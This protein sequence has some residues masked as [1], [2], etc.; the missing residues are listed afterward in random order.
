VLWLVSGY[1]YSQDNQ[2]NRY[3]HDPDYGLSGPAVMRCGAR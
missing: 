1:A 3:L 2:T